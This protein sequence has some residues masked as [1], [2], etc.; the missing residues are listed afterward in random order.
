MC[1][2]IVYTIEEDGKHYVKCYATVG[3]VEMTVPCEFIDTTN[4]NE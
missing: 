4:N 1:V 2:N 3:V